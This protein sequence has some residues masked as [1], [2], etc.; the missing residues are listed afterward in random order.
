MYWYNGV[1]V[2]KTLVV[3]RGSVPLVTTITRGLKTAETGVRGCERHKRCVISPEDATTSYAVNE[4]M[5]HFGEQQ[6]KIVSGVDG[7][8]QSYR[9]E[10]PMAYILLSSTRCWALR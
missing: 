9:K 6:C 3:D 5:N 10:P 7:L 4:A 1:Y 8:E 2:G